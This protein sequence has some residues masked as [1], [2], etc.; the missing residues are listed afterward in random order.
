MFAVGGNHVQRTELIECT[1]IC[2]IHTNQLAIIKPY[3]GSGT[4]M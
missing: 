1:S 2:R 4:I 3:I